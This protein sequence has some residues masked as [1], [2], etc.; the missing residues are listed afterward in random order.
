MNKNYKPALTDWEVFY[1]SCHT[2]EELVDVVSDYIGF[3]EDTV[4][5]SKTVKI[6][7]NNKPWFGKDLKQKLL[8]KQNL[9]SSSNDRNLMKLVQCDINNTIDTYKLEF[10]RKLESQFKSNN[11]KEAWK[12][13][14]LVTQYKPGSK[15]LSD[16]DG[17]LSDKL[18]TFYARFD[19]NDNTEDIETVKILLTRHQNQ[20]GLLSLM[21]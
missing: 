17:A 14:E 8:H 19:T 1:D 20:Q 16:D 18:N 9:L 5:P 4:V 6:Y 21:M 11:T 2:I 12:G 7:P 3:C 10:K 15:S 13:L